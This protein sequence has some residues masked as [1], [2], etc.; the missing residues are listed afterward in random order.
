MMMKEFAIETC[1]KVFM[2]ISNEE[3]K[4]PKAVQQDRINNLRFV[5]TLK[6]SDK[7]DVL[8]KLQQKNAIF[9]L[10]WMK[11][12]EA[13]R[14][15]DLSE[16][17]VKDAKAFD[18]TLKDEDIFQALRNI[19]IIW[20]LELLFD[21][22]LVYHEAMF[23]YSMLYPYSD[24]LLD[25]VTISTDEKRRFN[26]WFSKRLHGHHDPCTSYVYQKVDA[27]VSMIEHHFP[28]SQ[29]PHV[30]EGLYMIQDAQIAS[31]RQSEHLDIK[32]IFD[33]SVEKGGTSVIA[34]GYL[35]HGDMDKEQFQ[36]CVDFGFALQIVDDIQDQIEDGTHG[37]HTLA[38]KCK[39]KQQRARLFQQCWHFFDHILNGFACKRTAIQTFVKD[40]CHELLA[41]CVL[42]D[43]QL[44]PE[45]LVK[46]IM[47]ALP[48]ESKDIQELSKEMKEKMEHAAMTL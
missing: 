14:F 12:E 10:S 4:F 31:I 30:Y 41:Q 20:M 17:F 29:F 32:E 39:T 11:A 22:P 6:K 24:N 21:I 1:K 2:Q 16:R 3:I 45:T 19:W 27:L 44:Y 33:I 7:S 43:K 42:Q 35:I 8:R 34:D 37:H 18:D 25:D 23:A 28:R 48:L 13:N 46:D 5:N 9:D 40:S 15:Q 26:T 38:T 47:N 36:F